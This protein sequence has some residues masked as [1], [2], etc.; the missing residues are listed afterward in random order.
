MAE[1]F[2][3]DPTKEKPKAGKQE[4]ADAGKKEEYRAP[5]LSEIL[6]PEEL[7]VVQKRRD[8]EQAVQ[9]VGDSLCEGDPDYSWQWKHTKEIKWGPAVKE[10]FKEAP[11]TVTRERDDLVVPVSM[12][13]ARAFLR[14]SPAF[15]QANKMA[16]EKNFERKE[17]IAR[18][19]HAQE[20]AR[21]ALTV[22]M[23]R[24]PDGISGAP[25]VGEKNQINSLGA[26][27]ERL[28][29]LD[30]AVDF[31]SIHSALEAL[32]HNGSEYH[33]YRRLAELDR[34][35]E[36]IGEKLGSE[37][38]D[39]AH[40]NFDAKDTE[41]KD[42]Y[43]GYADALPILK[44]LLVLRRAMSKTTFGHEK[45]PNDVWA[46]DEARDA[47]EHVGETAQTL[48]VNADVKSA[49][50]EVAPESQDIKDNRDR[51][52]F[53]MRVRQLAA[54][55]GVP[56]S[57]K[58]FAPMLNDRRYNDPTTGP[59]LWKE[60]LAKITALTMDFRKDPRPV[61]DKKQ[62]A[63]KSA[64]FKRRLEELAKAMTAGME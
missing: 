55:V 20:L 49:T 22:L 12:L 15:Q 37:T 23:D 53:N 7:T 41:K 54:K 14:E 8:T 31:S 25:L 4:A 38:M 62:Y 9:Q 30:G 58:I 48:G 57:T 42:A 28:R 35:I 6:T 46:I 33:P 64:D 44:S 52:D 39:V 16:A 60:A 61:T 17:E 10:A 18:D 27:G 13:A 51:Q 50:A 32:S 11:G 47:A 3:K 63:E 36:E 5:R 24:Y 26:V 29:A 2:R 56:P 45:S 40:A 59:A 43:K 1:Q 34:I 19:R 21:K